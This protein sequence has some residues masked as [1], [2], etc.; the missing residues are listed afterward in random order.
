MTGRPL[1]R[2]LAVVALAIA[3]IASSTGA[4]AQGRAA[5]SPPS[6]SQE[7]KRRGDDLL[8]AKR[9]TEALA[10]YDEAYA[11]EP[12]V[13]LLYN[14]GRALQFLARYPEALESIKRFSQQASPELRA[15]VPGLAELLADLESKVS[16]LTIQCDVAGARV[17]LDGRQLGVCPFAAPVA[18]TA[19][20]PSLEALAEGYLPFRRDVTLPGGGAATVAVTLAARN[21]SAL[22]VVKSQVLAS[23]VVLDGQVLGLVPAETGVP[24]GEHVVRV[25]HEGYDPATTRVVVTAGER[26]EL[27][28]DPL[29]RPTILSRWWFW[30]GV[31]L[32]VV[33]ITT[34]VIVVSTERSPP[35]GNFSPG[36]VRF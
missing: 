21:T 19:G 9:F 5:P 14:R 1:R 17:L 12:N 13:S 23:R 30:T 27:V 26:K 11:T 6:P 8:E 32:V 3:A 22:L 15:R 25:E 2:A 35:E 29:A 18:V 24:A 7:M 10:A 4:H 33:G 31:G 34:A 28:L 20:S 36:T 16:T